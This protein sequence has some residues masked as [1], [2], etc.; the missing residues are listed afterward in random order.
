MKNAEFDKS[1]VTINE[2]KVEIPVEEIADY[3][4]FEM[5]DNDIKKMLKK[6]LE[7]ENGDILKMMFDLACSKI[8]N[9]EEYESTTKTAVKLAKSLFNNDFNEIW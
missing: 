2:D 6:L 3:I 1:I 7:N 4:T 5:S 8:T 9:S